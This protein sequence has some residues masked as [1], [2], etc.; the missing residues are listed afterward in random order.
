[1]PALVAGIH[2][3]G[4]ITARKT[5]MA[6][7][8]PAMT[9]LL[10]SPLPASIPHTESV[11]MAHYTPEFMASL[12]HDVEGTGLSL[13]AIATK[14]GISKRTLHRMID[15]GGWRKRSE[16]LHDLPAAARLLG[17]ATALLTESAKGE[18]KREPPTADPSPPFAARMGDGEDQGCEISRSSPPL[19]PGSTPS[20]IER[21]ERLVEKELTAEEAVRAQLGP[22]PRNAADAERTARTLS[23]LTQTLHALQRLRGGLAAE[24]QHDDDIPRDINEFRRELARRIEAFVASRT[25][26]ADAGSDPGAMV[27]KPRA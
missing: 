4:G 19:A 27:D 18:D 16:R 17:E 2:V 15:R 10:C 22:L 5:W 14:H 1:M 13:Q 11:D 25:D 23:T 24:T 8:S 3:F 9:S 6:G 20:A 21:L 12:K 26:G 7:S